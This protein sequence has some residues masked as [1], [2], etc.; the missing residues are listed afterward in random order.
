M[1]TTPLSFIFTLYLVLYPA[2]GV[3]LPGV[4]SM[5]GLVTEGNTLGTPSPYNG[6][7][8]LVRRNTPITHLHKSL[9]EMTLA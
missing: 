5:T 3:K 6:A 9:K 1:L 4:C 7:A 8:F 2:Q